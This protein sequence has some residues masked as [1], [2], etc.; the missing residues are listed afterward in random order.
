MFTFVQ[1]AA[2]NHCSHQLLGA[3]AV[4][5]IP[6]IVHRF[7][8]S[9]SRAI[10]QSQSLLSIVPLTQ[11]QGLLHCIVLGGVLGVMALRA[12]AGAGAGAGRSLQR[13]ARTVSTIH[14]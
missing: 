5:G 12:G 10:G 14:Q 1:A 6:E 7:I 11:L 9:T 13:L 4:A 2:H 3:S 8:S